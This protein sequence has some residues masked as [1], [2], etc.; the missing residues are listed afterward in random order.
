MDSYQITFDTWNKGAR[1]YQEKFMDL[2]LYNDTYDR[3]CGLIEKESPA[4]FEIGCGPGNITKYLLSKRPDFRIEAIDIAPNMIEL[5]RAN[6]PAARFAVMDCRQIDSLTAKY[7][8]IIAGFCMPYLSKED[9]AKLIKDCSALLHNGGILY[10]STIKG[11]YGN[12]GYRTAS[13][14]DECYIYYYDEDFFLS[15]LERN[16]FEPAELTYKLHPQPATPDAVEMIFIARK[17]D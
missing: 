15:K 7:D 4:V 12:S 3:F 6:N 17:R 11:D 5:A 9:N 8:A 16:S 14:G 13:T 1:L 2:D 10:F